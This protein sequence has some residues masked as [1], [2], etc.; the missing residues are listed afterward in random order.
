MLI[1]VGYEVCR[2]LGGI[3]TVLRSKAPAMMSRWADDYCLVGPYHADSAVEFEEQPARGVLA[4]AVADTGRAGIPCKYG[5]WLITGRPQV[6]LIDIFACMKRLAEYKYFFWKDHGITLPGDDW[7][8]NN[9]VVFGYCAAEF[10]SRLAAAAQKRNQTAGAEPASWPIIAHFHEWMGGAALPVLRHRRVPVRSVFTTHAT[11]LGRYLS[12]DQV[13]LYEVMDKIDADGTAA[14]Y[15]IQPRHA[16]E[17]A[18]AHSAHV[19]TAVSEVTGREAEKLL[20]RRVD[21]VTPNGLNI[22]RFS[23]VHEFQNLHRINKEKIHEFTTAHFFP[24]YSFDLDRTVYLLTSGRYEYRNKG[25]DLFIESLA[26]LNWRL[27]QEKSDVTVI[28]FV[29]TKAPFRNINV[30]V[31]RSR[32]M[33]EELRRTCHAIQEQMGRRLLARVSVGQMP[34]RVDDLLDEYAVVRLKRMSHAWRQ[35]RPPAVVTHDVSNDGSDPVLCQIR[36]CKLFNAKDDPVKIVFHPDFVTSAGPL[37]GMDY[38]DF[39]RGCHLGVFPSYYEPWGYTPLECLV[40]GVPSVTTDHAGFGSYILKNV[41]DPDEKG[42]FIV[43]RSKRSFNDAADQL[44]RIM[45]EFCGLTRRQRIELRNRAESLSEHFDWNNL[46][47]YYN[48]AHELA[49]RRA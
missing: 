13:D 40:S 17:K 35:G 26:R 31:L 36:A 45:L 42:I 14:R 12:A 11:L 24:A 48:E 39:V 37:L 22:E 5:R 21:V 43:R 29:I 25:Y 32:S 9:V 47:R 38:P 41:P 44:T 30:D 20:G 4:D 2:Q 49:L 19:F 15:N 27:K 1:E 18:A 8:V 46:V 3:Y 33:Y 34:A 6:V 16:I 10:L 7:E 23:A 28:A